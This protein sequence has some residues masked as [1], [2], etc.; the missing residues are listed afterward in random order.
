MG[1]D[2]L[3][4][5]L[6]YPMFIVTATDGTRRAG[7]LIGFASQCSIDPP[8]FMVWLSKNNHT[9][10]VAKRADVLAV[11]VPTKANRDLAVLFGTRTGF[12][13]DKFDQCDWRAG[14]GGVPVLADCPQWF[15]GRVLSRHDTGDHVGLLLAPDTVGPDGGRGQLGYQE[16]RD[17]DAGNEA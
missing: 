13:V 17:L 6:D 15:C 9:Y 12:E 5:E 16:V 1:F 7:C 14:P 11:H 8:R 10:L 3:V 2:A 4:G